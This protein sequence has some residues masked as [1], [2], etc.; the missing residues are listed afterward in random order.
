MTSRRN[1]LKTVSASAAISCLSPFNRSLRAEENSSATSIGAG[2][3]RFDCDHQWAQLPQHV[4]WTNT[5]GV[6]VDRQGLIYV[7]HQGDAQAPC[8][9]V[10]VFDSSGTFVRSFGREFAGGGHGISIRREGN[11]EFLYLCDIHNRQVVKCDTNGEWVW[12][13]RYPR[14]ANFYESVN[15]FR[16]T[17]V[18]FAPNGDF[19]VADG[20]GA[21]IIHHYDIHARWLGSLG[22]TGSNPG[23]L[24]T[25]H[26]L[27]YSTFAE[28]PHSLIVADRGNSR[29]QFFSPDGQP[30]KIVQGVN[31]LHKHAAEKNQGDDSADPSLET[32]SCPELSFPAD[33]AIWEDMILVADLHARILLFDSS[34]Q[35][36]AQP[37]YDPNWTQKVLS[38][39]SIRKQTDSWRP[40][41]FIHP[42]GSCFDE[43]GNIYIVEWVET[44]RVTK[45]TWL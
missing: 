44:G 11:V 39:K 21:N 42:H 35:L 10:V 27:T 9:T 3:F 4:K 20:Y 25:P 37:G 17:N 34:L 23:E 45:L 7:I 30:Q 14:E 5:H 18:C 6:A 8:D 2:D 31:E 43:D 13:I 12:K 1:F 26:S 29:L 41:K 16:P 24:Q 33:I 19:Y 32:I 36:L 22:K 15:N 38:D 28:K 40:G